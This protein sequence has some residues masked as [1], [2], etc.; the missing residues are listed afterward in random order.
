MTIQ[1]AGESAH[2][3]IERLEKSRK[4]DALVGT[5]AGQRLLDAAWREQKAARA[6]ARKGDAS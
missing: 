6:A 3:A 4:W 5:D 1:R 2:A